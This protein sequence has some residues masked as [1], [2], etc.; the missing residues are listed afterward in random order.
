M[1]NPERLHRPKSPPSKIQEIQLPSVLKGFRNDVGPE[2][3]A[4]IRAAP[5]VA[6]INKDLVCSFATKETEELFKKLHTFQLLPKE[7][8]KNP[9]S[10]MC[11]VWKSF[12]LSYSTKPECS[13]KPMICVKMD[14]RD[15]NCSYIIRSFPLEMDKA[16][17]VNEI[18]LM[19]TIETISEETKIA[20]FNLTKRE[21]E[22]V[23]LLMKEFDYKK[24]GE[25]LFVSTHTVQS[26]IKN[27]KMKLKVNN[28]LSIILKILGL[29]QIFSSPV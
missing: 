16:F 15:Q 4:S 25:I 26:H 2:K 1:K 13:L 24:I 20:Q 28:K 6:F 27:I 7:I 18:I 3:I 23:G 21:K 9:Y 8:G 11:E 22:V 12:F 29:D 14:K 10:K 17:K 19:V 5:A